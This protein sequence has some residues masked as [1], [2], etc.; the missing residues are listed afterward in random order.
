MMCGLESPRRG[1]EAKATFLGGRNAA[2]EGWK[3][4]V[5]CVIRVHGY[6]VR[7]GADRGGRMIQS[8]D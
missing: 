6:I 5:H 2:V 7:R 8:I 1:R 4:G 3:G